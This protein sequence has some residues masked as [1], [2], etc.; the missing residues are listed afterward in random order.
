MSKKEEKENLVLI[1][2]D[3]YRIML[4]ECRD[5][6]NGL[7]NTYYL[8]CDGLSDYFNEW[9]AEHSDSDCPQDDTCECPEHQKMIQAWEQFSKETTWATRRIDKIN[10]ALNELEKNKKEGKNKKII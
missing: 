1:N 6:L 4:E 5:R 3:D 9:G 2:V 8:E 10:R 7:I